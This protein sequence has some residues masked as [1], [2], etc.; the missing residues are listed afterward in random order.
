[1]SAD[2]KTEK[3]DS[4]DEGQE[5]N[6]LDNPGLLIPTECE[7]AENCG[8]SS[9]EKLYEVF[10][11]SARRWESI[12]YPSLIAFIILAV[13]GFYL[14]FSLTTNVT[15][16]VSHMD[17]ISTRMVQISTD[18]QKVSN[19]MAKM[20]RNIDSMTVNMDNM[21]KDIR[22]QLSEIRD[23]KVAVTN[24]SQTVRVMTV[25]MDQMRRDLSI[26]NHSVSRPMNFMNSFMPW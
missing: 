13:Y 15:K 16:V 18:M 19:N 1:M 3:P 5:K 21:S 25:T 11:A 20:T 6:K 24:M 8:V 26:M 22:S 23:M 4:K 7:N 2:K 9:L 12:V 10:A 14:I 17:I